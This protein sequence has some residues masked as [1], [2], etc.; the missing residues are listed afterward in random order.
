MYYSSGIRSLAWCHQI[1]PRNTQPQHK[2]APPCY[3]P[4]ALPSLPMEL[5]S[6]APNHA[7][8]APQG[9]MQASG[10]AGLFSP[11]SFP[12]FW[13]LKHDP[14]KMRVEGGGLLL[15]GRCLFAEATTN[16]SLLYTVGRI[17]ENGWWGRFPVVQDSE[18]SDTKISMIKY[19]SWW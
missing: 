17:L 13:A 8:A 9:L 18:S 10:G 16:Q 5:S 12:L 4:V 6:I 1:S 7:A 19:T 11:L 14:W 2:M 3:I 15:C